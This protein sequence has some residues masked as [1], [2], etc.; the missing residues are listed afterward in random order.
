M[1][2][3]KWSLI[4]IRPESSYEKLEAKLTKKST[5]DR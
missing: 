4:S 2:A 1:N 3:R 5:K